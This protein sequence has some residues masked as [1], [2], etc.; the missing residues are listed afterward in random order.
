MQLAID[1]CQCVRPLTELTG[2]SALVL[3][4]AEANAASLSKAQEEHSHLQK[5]VLGDLK[6]ATSR[7]QYADAIDMC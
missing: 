1:A 2:H 3:Q 6:C 5:A 7:S 4:A